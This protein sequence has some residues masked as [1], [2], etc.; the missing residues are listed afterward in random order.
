VTGGVCVERLAMMGG[1]EHRGCQHGAELR[2]LPAEGAGPG[3]EV[4]VAPSTVK[5]GKQSVAGVWGPGDAASP[6]HA[7]LEED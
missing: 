3:M 5:E 6:Q 4:P 2:V 1:G 7:A